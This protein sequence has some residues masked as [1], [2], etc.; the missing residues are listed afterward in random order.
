MQ[1]DVVFLGRV[2]AVFK[3]RYGYDSTA[4]VEVVTVWKG[5]EWLAPRVAVDG[6]GGPTY[7]ARI[8]KRGETAL[9]YL[10]VIEKGKRFRADSFLHR[11]VAEPAA[12]EDL[13][14][15]SGLRAP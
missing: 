11:V 3:D 7:P 13:S 4:D 2:R 8:F 12:A 5:R 9:F 6:S 14:F 15:L 10:A 1:A